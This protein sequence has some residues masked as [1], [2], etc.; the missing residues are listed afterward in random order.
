LLAKLKEF[1]GAEEGGGMAGGGIISRGRE[2]LD[3]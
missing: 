3:A 1:V 2:A